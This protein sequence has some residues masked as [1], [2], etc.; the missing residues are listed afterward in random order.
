MALISK[1]NKEF[2]KYEIN[3]NRKA[4]TKENF[5]MLQLTAYFHYLKIKLNGTAFSEIESEK[6]RYYIPFSFTLNETLAIVKNHGMKMLYLEV[7]ENNYIEISFDTIAITGTEDLI[8][9]CKETI[10]LAEQFKE[11][12]GF[13]YH[14]MAESAEWLWNKY[15]NSQFENCMEIGNM[16]F[17]NG[18]IMIYPT[19]YEETEVIYSDEFYAYKGQ[20]EYVL[21]RSNVEENKFL[22]IDNI[23]KEVFGGGFD[24]LEEAELSGILKGEN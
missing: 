20:I 19:E 22:L 6:N 13:Y 23:T 12:P 9:M 16:L 2:R 1:T 24:S 8:S 15:M 14:N 18:Y 11:A 3:V 5:R 10:S 17:G 21:I 4:F 7:D